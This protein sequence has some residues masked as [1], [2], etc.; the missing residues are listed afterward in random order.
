MPSLTV[1]SLIHHVGGVSQPRV[2]PDLIR[3]DA[4]TPV[5]LSHASPSRIRHWNVL[6]GSANGVPPAAGSSALGGQP[7]RS[8]PLRPAPAGNDASLARFDGTANN[9]ALT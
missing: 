6:L 3:R 8:S 4:L 1:A 9:A 7:H 2:P 5:A